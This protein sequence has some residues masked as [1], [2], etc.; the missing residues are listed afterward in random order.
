VKRETLTVLFL[1]NITQPIVNQ[2]SW[3]EKHWLNPNPWSIVG[4]AE[5]VP[6]FC[7]WTLKTQVERGLSWVG[8]LL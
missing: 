3:V 7:A 1:S 4:Q 6:L 5:K 2:C 8:H